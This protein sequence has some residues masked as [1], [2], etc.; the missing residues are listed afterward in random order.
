MLCHAVIRPGHDGWLDQVDEAIAS[1]PDSWKGYTIGD[2]LQPSKLPWRLDDEKTV[3]PFYEKISKAGINTVCIHKGLITRDYEAAF[4]DVWKH[5]TVDDVGKAARDWPGLNFVIYH[6]ALRPFIEV[7][8]VDAAE[9]E[10][11]GYIQ[12]VSD[13]A[14][15]PE[16]FGV[17]NVYGEIGTSFANTVVT[18]PR[19]TAGMLGTLIAG[20]GIERVLWGTDSTWYGSP[21]WQIEAFRRLEIPDDLQAKHGFA[22]LG[23]ATGP[24]KSAILWNNSAKLYGLDSHASAG[25]IGGDAIDSIRA[26]YRAHGIGRSNRAYGYVSVG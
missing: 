11:T 16:K 20:L 9:F 10:K 19:L 23:D 18:H 17:N 22:P 24:V 7:P 12:W 21:Q 15:I 2:P 25:T 26:E 5:A 6:S 8:D 13:L 14:R 3:Y 4:P 1:R